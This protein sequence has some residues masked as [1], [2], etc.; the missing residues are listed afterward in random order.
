MNTQQ[1]IQDDSDFVAQY[2]NE[3]HP[4]RANLGRP[5]CFCGTA[6]VNVDADINPYCE[7]HEE[8]DGYDPELDHD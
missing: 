1:R 7:E 5:V 6:A 3:Q 4:D 8:I 2:M